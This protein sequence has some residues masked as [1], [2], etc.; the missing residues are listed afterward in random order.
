MSKVAD[1][2]RRAIFDAVAA[3]GRLAEPLL[4]RALAD[5]DPSVR[6][7]ATSGAGSSGMKPLGNAIL[8]ALT[9]EKHAVVRGSIIVALGKLRLTSAVT[10][11]S[12]I[13]QS[14]GANEREAMY[15]LGRIGNA[16][17]RT[18]LST[19]ELGTND[20]DRRKLARFLLSD[21]FLRQ[22]KA[23]GEPWTRDL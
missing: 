10:A 15:A 4:S 9:T 22:E 1:E 14:A 21:D 18:H 2:R 5:P 6:D 19:I 3:H 11:V 12:E 16:D 8:A 13:A 17:A 23:L 20:E 7:A